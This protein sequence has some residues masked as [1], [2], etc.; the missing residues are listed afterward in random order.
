MSAS[1]NKSDLGLHLCK[2]F[3]VP[4]LRKSTPSQHAK[5]ASGCDA[6]KSAAQGLVPK[7]VGCQKAG[8]SG[9]CKPIQTDT[10]TISTPTMTSI[11]AYR[12]QLYDRRQRRAAAANTATRFSAQALRNSFPYFVMKCRSSR[13]IALMHCRKL[14][15]I[16]SE[17]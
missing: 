17:V 12:V 9:G 1:K 5:H 11:P 3:L 2:Q 7:S 4:G 14:L 16:R 10:R 6:G 8:Q 13:A 15:L